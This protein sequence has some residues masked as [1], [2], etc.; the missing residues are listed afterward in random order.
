MKKK[1]IFVSILT[2][3]LSLTLITCVSA[4]NNTN[5]NIQV[6][7]TNN[8][9]NLLLNENNNI[10]NSNYNGIQNTNNLQSNSNTIYISPNGGG[11]GSSIS[12]PTNWW[13]A[14][15]NIN[16]NGNIIFTN[17]TYNLI[18]INLDKSLTLSNYNNGEVILNGNNNGYIFHSSKDTTLTLQGL[19][20]TSATGYK[21]N[22]NLAYGGAINSEGDLNIINCKFLNNNA[23]TGGAVYGVN[24]SI[25]NS[26]F[27]ANHATYSS[28]AVYASKNCEIINSEFNGNYVTVQEAGAVRCVE[29]ATII[30]SSFT[31]NTAPYLAGAIYCKN[32]IVDSSNFTGNKL[33]NKGSGGAIYCEKNSQVIDSNFISNSASYSGALHSAGNTLI[34]SSTFISNTATLYGGAI[35]TITGNING[36]VFLYNIAPK[37]NSI[38]YTSTCDADYNWWGE[39]TPFNTGNNNIYYHT[40][41]KYSNDN[42]TNVQANNWVIMTMSTNTTSINNNETLKVTVNLNNVID[43]NGQITSSNIKLPIR[44][45]NYNCTNGNFKANSLNIQGIVTNTYTNNDYNGVVN[46]TSTIDKQSL[47]IPVKVG[48]N[49]K[50]ITIKDNVLYTTENGT[51]N[52]KVSSSTGTVNTGFISLYYNNNLIGSFNI[53][54]NEAKIL[55]NLKTGEYNV[56]LNYNGLNIYMNISKDL[57]LNV[58]N[59]TNYTILSADDFSEKY[60]EGLNFTGKLIDSE[61]NPII[62]QHIKLNLTR[63]SDGASKDYWATTDNNGEYQLQINLFSGNY[64]GQA[65]YYGNDIYLASNSSLAKIIVYN[66]VKNPTLI[67]ADSFQH[68]YGSGLNFTGKLISKSTGSLLVGQHVKLTLSRTSDGASKD[69]WVTTDSFGEYQLPINLYHGSYKVTCTYFGNNQYDFSTCNSTIIVY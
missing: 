28:G 51:I 47:T 15:N 52:I 24:I 48:S 7:D 8:S 30:N 57:T 3:I 38:S 32:I 22:Y 1:I 61:G 53:T 12:S 41:D 13:N 11:S 18:N 55:N 69:Y 33:T 64:T 58:Y 60:G 9:N 2:I 19:T 27:T 43:T 66:Q 26:V 39:N 50:D 68:P 44:T 14:Y 21:N 23:T 62:G 45:V 25:L 46:L 5:N 35:N 49:Y 63:L 67:S 16:N 56:T 37:G 65:T 31:G 42:G 29:N 34:K 20:F 54:N 4:T 36:N 40:I 17:G 59:S 6:N 10:N